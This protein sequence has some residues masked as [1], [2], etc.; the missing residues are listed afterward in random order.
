[1]ITTL[2]ESNNTQPFYND[3]F[4]L[5]FDTVFDVLSWVYNENGSDSF[6]GTSDN[7]FFLYFDT[8]FDALLSVYNEN[9]NDNDND[10]NSF[11]RTGDTKIF[12]EIFNNESLY[13]NNN[14]NLL[15]CTGI[16]LQ[17]NDT[18][19]TMFYYPLHVIDHGSV[20][21]LILQTLLYNQQYVYDDG[22]N[23]SVSFVTQQTD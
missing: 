18:A 4:D 8:V 17:N 10:S 19:I 23:D 2:N 15:G 6:D 12:Y 5:Y 14:H 9:D 13:D 11:G 22:N 1:M 16:T 7:V 21:Y 20:L 3:D